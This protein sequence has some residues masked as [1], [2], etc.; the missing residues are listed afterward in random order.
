MVAKGTFPFK[1]KSPWQN[2][3]TNPGPHDQYSEIL[4]TRP[5]GWSQKDV[6]GG[7]LLQFI[8]NTKVITIGHV[9]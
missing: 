6:Y 3:E 9:T 1:E 5:R 4:T 8:L 2:R 7:I